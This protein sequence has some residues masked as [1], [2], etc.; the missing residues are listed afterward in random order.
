MLDKEWIVYS[1]NLSVLYINLLFFQFVLCMYS[2]F[3]LVF[4]QMYICVDAYSL[5]SLLYTYAYSCAHVHTNLWRPQSLLILFIEVES[6]SYKA[7]SF[8]SMIIWIVNLPLGIAVWNILCTGMTDGTSH[9]CRFYVSVVG[10]NF[11]PYG[12]IWILEYARYP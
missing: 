2:L 12:C 4:L 11:D 5:I 1:Y 6:L 10:P 9:M 8:T 3:V 7:Q